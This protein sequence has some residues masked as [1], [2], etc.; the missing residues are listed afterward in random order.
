MQHDHV[1]G[2]HAQLEGGRPR[3]D[4][5]RVARVEDRDLNGARFGGVARGVTRNRA[6]TPPNRVEYRWSAIINTA[7]RAYRVGV[8]AGTR[9]PGAPATEG[10]LSSLLPATARRTLSIGKPLSNGEQSGLAVQQSVAVETEIAPGVFRLIVR[11][12]AILDD[13]RRAKPSEARFRFEPCIR[14]VGSFP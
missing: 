11:D 2:G 6:E 14:P 10:T 9:A 13:L 7:D 4:Q 12:K 8:N 1:D 3:T 5:R